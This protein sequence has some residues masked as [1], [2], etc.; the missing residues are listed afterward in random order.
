MIVCF[1]R[2]AG[3]VETANAEANA[4]TADAMV[5][6]SKVLT[7]HKATLALIPNENACID[8]S[9]SASRERIKVLATMGLLKVRTLA[10]FF[11]KWNKWNEWNERI[12]T[13]ERIAD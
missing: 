7:W 4:P 3:L 8:A 2:V 13:G 1:V 9:A 5:A 6:A 12:T 11:Y 10:S